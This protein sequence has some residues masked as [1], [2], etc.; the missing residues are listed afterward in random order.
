MSRLREGTDRAPAAIVALPQVAP[1]SPPQTWPPRPLLAAGLL[2]LAFLTVLSENLEYR[3]CTEVFQE[4]PVS[5]CFMHE[6]SEMFLFPRN[7]SP[8]GG[9]V[10]PS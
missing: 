7:S 3:R 4:W 6:N 9:V 1:V 2:Q 10:S 8:R 5:L